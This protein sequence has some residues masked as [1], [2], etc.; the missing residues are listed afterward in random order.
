MLITSILSAIG[1]NNSIYP[2]IVRDCGIEV[3]AKIIL[4]YNQNKKESKEVA[5][6]AAR[7]RFLDE[8]SV[9]AAWLGGIPLV[10]KIIDY[11]IRKKEFRQGLS[12]L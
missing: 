6:L 11:F 5:K 7:E 12:F 2:L 3:P 4:T 9:S 1:N 8:Y 10:G